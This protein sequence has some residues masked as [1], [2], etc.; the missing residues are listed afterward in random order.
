MDSEKKHMP[1]D[2]MILTSFWLVM[3]FL[4]LAA[5]APLAQRYETALFPIVTDFTVRRVEQHGDW[6][7]LSGDMAKARDCE[8]L[9]LTFYAGDPDDLERPRERLHVAFLDQPE[10]VDET[11][12]PGRQP[13][14]PWRVTRPQNLSHPRVFMRVNHHCHPLWHS[15]GVYLDLPVADVFGASGRPES[16]DGP[17][18]Y[19]AWRDAAP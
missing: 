14:G 19:R 2:R 13:W 7:V 17:D 15:S 1:A 5:L 12:L 4:V 16:L 11:R 6:V 10:G 9:S 18:S 3:G 8:F